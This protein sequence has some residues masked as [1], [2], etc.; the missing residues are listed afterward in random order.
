MSIRPATRLQSITGKIK[1]AHEDKEDDVRIKHQRPSSK[2]MV[3]ESGKGA[4][5]D[6]L[7]AEGAVQ[8]SFSLASTFS[9]DVSK[10]MIKEGSNL[11]GWR[12]GAE[13]QENTNDIWPQSA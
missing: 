8:S 7:F 10:I 2:Q 4:R 3:K 9:A 13:T 11:Q 12:C 6:T 5:R 1:G